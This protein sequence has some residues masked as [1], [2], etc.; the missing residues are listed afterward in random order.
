MYISLIVVLGLRATSVTTHT[1]T[2]SW[3]PPIHLIPVNYKISYNAYK[4]FV[5]AQGVTQNAKIPTVT[6]LVSHKANE[7]VIKELS[8]FT[9]YH[10]NV[11][12]IPS[13]RNYRPPAKITVTT[14]M[15]APQPMVK[16]DFYGVRKASGGELTVFLPQ[17]SEEYGPISHY[18][19]VV[20]PNSN[21]SNVNFPDQYNTADLNRPPKGGDDSHPYIA[22]KFLQR[23]IPYTFVLG[24]GD[25]YEGY[26]NKPLKPQTMYK[27]FVRAYVDTPQKHLYTSSPF[28]PELSLDMMQE[29]PGPP[30]ERPR[31]GDHPGGGTG[32]P[33]K[34][35][36]STMTTT[37]VAI[38]LAAIFVIFLVILICVLRK[39]KQ[40]QK[41]PLGEQGAVMTPLMSGFRDMNNAGNGA[42]NGAGGMEGMAVNSGNGIGGIATTDPVELRRLNFQTPGMMSHPPIPVP[43]LATH[44]DLLK[45]N[46]NMKFS[47]EYESIEP[48]QQFTWDNSS[49]EINKP[50]NRYANVIAYDHSRVVLQPI[51]GIPGSDY[52][53]GNYC[54]GYRKQNAYIAT[55]VCVKIQSIFLL[56]NF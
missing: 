47:Q 40:N 44:I 54:D 55:Q 42:G 38:I 48:G 11:S 6:I 34:H 23:S 7:Y 4:E 22:A 32:N 39:R 26:I 56:A 12:A 10:V 20:I 41:Q 36:K 31:P 46:D 18:Y 45:M 2:L 29:P 9:T 8:P 27:I 43:E 13:D 15:A 33:K 28:S 30:P 35:R 53:N 37:I 14:Q 19:V 51:D 50:K 17:A 5:D 49:M 25:N 1:M 3:G 24:N 21:A 16:P 52:I